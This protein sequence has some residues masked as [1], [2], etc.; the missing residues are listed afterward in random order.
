MPDY[1]ISASGTITSSGIG[2]IV[3]IPIPDKDYDIDY[4]LKDLNLSASGTSTSSG[5]AKIT[6]IIIPTFDSNITITVESNPTNIKIKN[7]DG[8]IVAE[9]DIGEIVGGNNADPVTVK[10]LNST[11]AEDD[12]EVTL[13]GEATGIDIT[14][15][16]TLDPFSGSQSLSY[17]GVT[18]EEEITFYARLET[19]G[20]AESG[21]GS[22][23]LSVEAV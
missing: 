10:F 19:T 21:S 5:T 6:K 8:D 15:S 23:T 13:S 2:D 4:I 16:K 1:E 3:L 14:L 11:G 20:D 22:A 9:I 7:A 18:N 17:S 12:F